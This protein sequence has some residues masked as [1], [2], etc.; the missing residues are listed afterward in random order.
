MATVRKL[1]SSR[2]G[3]STVYEGNLGPMII[4]LIIVFGIVYYAI[5]ATP[6]ER[7]KIGIELPKFS[8]EYLEVS[9]GLIKATPE[10]SKEAGLH[11]MADIL[12]DGRPV[13]KTNQLLPQATLSKSVFSDQIANITFSIDKD[14]VVRTSVTG[15]VKTASSPAEIDALINGVDIGSKA[16]RAGQQF[17]F[18]LPTSYISQ[19][20]TLQLKLK[21]AS[22][23]KT[24]TYELADINLI[25]S[26]YDSVRA[27]VQ[28]SFTMNDV[29]LSGFTG[30]TVSAYIKSLTETPGRLAID[31]NSNNVYD[32]YPLRD[33]SLKLARQDFRA[34]Q[35]NLVLKVSRDAAYGLSFPQ[36]NTEFTREPT[37]QGKQYSFQVSSFVM[38]KSRAGL[39]NCPLAI[40]SVSNGELDIIIN[41]NTITEQF[42][43]GT[44]NLDICRYFRQGDNTLSLSSSRDL[45]VGRL[46]LSVREK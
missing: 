30:A 4:L 20:N 10:A 18:S 39:M 9:P 42:Q 5:V 37:T 45:L 31:L 25:T 43:N 44:I 38:A 7:K 29:E 26:E 12:V 41:S 17:T 1:R 6:D 27:K 16:V 36:V 40:E 3:D 35:N 34:G 19:K 11:Q 33:F 13:E 14:N 46:A 2:K 24:T 22:P 21:G 23:F 28:R 8:K 15:R 32:D